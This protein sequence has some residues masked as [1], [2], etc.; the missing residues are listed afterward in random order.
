M[1]QLSK[2]PPNWLLVA[3]VFLGFASASLPPPQL[4]GSIKSITRNPR[5]FYVSS[6]TSTSFA[7]TR[8]YIASATGPCKRKRRT[9]VSDDSES[10][11]TNLAVVPSF[12]RSV[13]KEEIAEKREAKMFL[14]W[15]TTTSTTTSYTATSTFATLECVPNG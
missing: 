3:T 9:L 8:C 2:M 14:Y 4:S 12:A 10:Y 11:N 15:V 1:G 7:T 13:E 5:L 6:T